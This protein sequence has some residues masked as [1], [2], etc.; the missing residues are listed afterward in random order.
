[1]APVITPGGVLRDAETGV[2]AIGTGGL[3]VASNPASKANVQLATDA[4]S[5][6]NAVSSPFTS[7]TQFFHILTDKNVWIRVGEFTLGAALIIV[8][9]AHLMG[10]DSA[11]AKLATKLPLV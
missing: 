4:S 5:A 2:E 8:G 6:A 3:S 9:L 1:M 11:A 7:V 10:A